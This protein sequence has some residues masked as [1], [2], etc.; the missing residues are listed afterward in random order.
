ME[1][2]SRSLTQTLVFNDLFSVTHAQQEH[3]NLSSEMTQRDDLFKSLEEMCIQLTSS[4]SSATTTNTTTTTTS[5]SHS[6]QQQHANK[7]DIIVRTNVAMM[8]RERLFR[9]WKIKDEVLEAQRE[10][11][12]FYRD[13]NQVLGNIGSM[14]VMMAKAYAE[15]DA[16]HNTAEQPRL[17]VDDL[18]SLAKTNENLKKKIDKQSRERVEELQKKAET[19]I[20]CERARLEAMDPSVRAIFDLK[21]IGRLEELLFQVAL[22]FNFFSYYYLVSN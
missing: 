13:A 14:E 22:N 21:E 8:E 2:T 7:K 5:S 11:H 1:E 17:N 16:A 9:L 19:L 10:C 18:E 20:E 12:E 3:D 6:Q 15:L 4:S